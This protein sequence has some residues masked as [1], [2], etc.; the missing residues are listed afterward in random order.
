[1]TMARIF[2]SFADSKYEPSLRRIGRQ[3]E[4]M[5][6][7]DRIW[8]RRERDLSHTFVQRHHELLRSRVRGFG[9]FIW[10]PQVVLEALDRCNDGDV[11]HY[12]DAGC[13]LLVAG[14]KRL[15]E[16]FALAEAASSGVL[17]FQ[18][19]PPRPPFPHDG[20][21]LPHFRN[22]EWCKADLLDRFGLLSDHEFLE[23]YTVA[24]TTFFVRKSEATMA[25]I[26]EWRDF[27]QNNVVL[28]DDSP[29]RLPESFRFR[30]HR[31]DQAVF[32][33]LAY[34]HGFDS[35]SAYEFDYPSLPGEPRPCKIVATYPICAVR[36]K[37]YT[38]QY[39]FMNKLRSLWSSLF[40][41]S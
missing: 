10:K 20:R 3:A 29:S 4:A 2:V 37:K 38:I 8:L 24:A 25:I 28:I 9:Y 21:P 36:D 13:H 23:S 18:F 39:R 30:E 32:G 1:M 6:V 12:C 7:Y 34:M 33:C 40:A 27:M 17:A 41:C 14:R 15:L 35:L 19:D 31:H 26:R 22:I 16:Y 5:R 11:V